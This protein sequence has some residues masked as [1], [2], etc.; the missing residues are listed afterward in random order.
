MES[1]IAIRHTQGVCWRRRFS[2]DKDIKLPI[3][4]FVCLLFISLITSFSHGLTVISCLVKVIRSCTR[5]PSF[6]V[7]L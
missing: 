5:S 7:V 1:G 6:F 2:V 3:L 4:P